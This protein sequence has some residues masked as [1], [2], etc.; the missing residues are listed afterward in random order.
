MDEYMDLASL[1]K[2]LRRFKY[3]VILIAA[4]VIFVHFV[5]CVSSSRWVEVGVT[6]MKEAEIL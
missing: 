2:C 3:C 6:A 5:E 4:Y 1:F